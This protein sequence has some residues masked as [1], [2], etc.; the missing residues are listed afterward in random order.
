MMQQ[1]AAL[2]PLGCTL[3]SGA[4]L[5]VQLGH[6]ILA[7]HLGHTVGSP[8]SATVS[9][10]RCSLHMEAMLDRTVA[11]CLADAVARIIAAIALLQS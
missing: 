8:W 5:F 7:H 3:F 6:L 11:R 10:Q 1:H 4:R 9:R 2:Q